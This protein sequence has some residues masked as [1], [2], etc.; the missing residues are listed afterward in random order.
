MSTITKR[1]KSEMNIISEI[2]EKE[3]EETRKLAE[4]NISKA[5]DFIK[6]KR[7]TKKYRRGDY[8]NISGKDLEPRIIYRN[9]HVKINTLKE[10]TIKGARS[11]IQS[12]SNKTP[13]NNVVIQVGSNDLDLEDSIDQV[14]LPFME[15]LKETKE[16]MP[17]DCNI[18][19]GEILPRFYQ[20]RTETRKF[21]I[22]RQKNL[23]RND[24][25]DGIH[26]SLEKGVPTYVR[27]LKEILNPILGISSGNN[28]QRRERV[29]YNRGY[30]Q[31]YGIQNRHQSYS[32][33]HQYTNY[34]DNQYQNGR[35]YPSYQND[36]EHL[37]HQ[38]EKE[39]QRYPNER[40]YQNRQENYRHIQMDQNY[41]YQSD[42]RNNVNHENDN[43]EILM[44]QLLRKLSFN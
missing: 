24:F 1:I 33:G 25:M 13:I 22:I 29:Q 44:K 9:E 8:T 4:K 40:E 11:F 41:P 7:T 26:L 31:Q 34:I 43:M 39:Y 23:T 21:T 20:N 42:E 27:N 37:R 6:I 12:Q 35:E 16:S 19:V 30:N 10:K 36:R 2:V 18:F 38:N 5:I 32:N 17:P 28:Q 15:L 3:H 14:I